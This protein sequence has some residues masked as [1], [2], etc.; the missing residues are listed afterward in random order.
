MHKNTIECLRKISEREG[1]PKLTDLAMTYMGSKA[2]TIITQ[3]FNTV[4][5][6]GKGKDQFLNMKN[7]TELIQFLVFKGFIKE[8]IRSLEERMPISYLTCGNVVG[9]VESSCQVFFSL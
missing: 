7:A 9:L 4:A 2:K 8:N 5:Q 1:K 3:S 6:Y